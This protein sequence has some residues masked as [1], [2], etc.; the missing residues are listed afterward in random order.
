MPID[1]P[2]P[3]KKGSLC[4]WLHGRFQ[5]STFNSLRTRGT[6]LLTKGLTGPKIMALKPKEFEPNCI[7]LYKFVW[8]EDEDTYSWPL[9]LHGVVTVWWSIGDNVAIWQLFLSACSHSF[10]WKE[11]NRSPTPDPAFWDHKLWSNIEAAPL[12]LG[13]HTSLVVVLHLRLVKHVRGEIFW[14]TTCISQ[15]GTSGCHLWVLLKNWLS[16]ILQ[17]PRFLWKTARLK[18]ISLSF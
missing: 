15:L 14:A 5:L 12:D 3:G 7:I 9:T 1:S 4:K 18:S 17:L 6:K 13:P 8:N 2:G 11:A 10:V 16:F